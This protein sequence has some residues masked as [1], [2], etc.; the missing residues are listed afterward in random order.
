MRCQYD[1]F[2]SKKR[3]PTFTA[4]ISALQADGRWRLS[5]GVIEEMQESRLDP[6]MATYGEAILTLEQDQQWG[7]AINLLEEARAARLQ[8]DEDAYLA[9]IQV[10]ERA[11]QDGVAQRLEE[12]LMVHRLKAEDTEGRTAGMSSR[13]LRQI[14]GAFF[15]ERW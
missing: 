13:L 7:Q 3:L 6:D 2:R 14:S 1:S 12:E 9:T 11:H 15:D 4:A 8:P 5:V 10:V